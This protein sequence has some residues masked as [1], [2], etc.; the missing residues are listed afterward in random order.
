MLCSGLQFIVSVR[1]P[2]S[3]S[4]FA[5]GSSTLFHGHLRRASFP[6]SRAQLGGGA[7]GAVG[8]QFFGFL[9]GR[10]PHDLDGIADHVGWALLASRPPR[11]DETLPP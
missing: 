11:H 6:A 10:D 8:F 1:F 4:G 9:A 7:F 2:S 3:G 5:G